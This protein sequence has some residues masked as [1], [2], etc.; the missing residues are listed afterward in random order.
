[1]EPGLRDRENADATHRYPTAGYSRNGARPE[2]PGKRL[3]QAALRVSAS[4]AVE[5]GLRDRENSRARP[6]TGGSSGGSNGARPERPGKPAQSVHPLVGEQLAA[7]E[8][9]L[10]DRENPPAYA[11]R[12]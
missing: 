2:R 7:M 11:S 10:R 6:G 4:A 1:M 8:P 12:L 9:G 5:P 3:G